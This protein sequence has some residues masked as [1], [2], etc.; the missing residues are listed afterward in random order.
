MSAAGQATGNPTVAGG[1]NSGSAVG[2]A[3]GVPTAANGANSGTANGEATGNP[4]NVQPTDNSANVRPT[5]NP[6]AEGGLNSNSAG[7]QATANSANDQVPT[8]SADRQ[9]SGVPTAV[10]DGNSGSSGPQATINP[11]APGASDL[12][13]VRS[14]AAA[15]PTNAELGPSGTKGGTGLAGPPQA[16]GDRADRFR[17][18]RPQAGSIT[19][20]SPVWDDPA[21][22]QQNPVPSYAPAHA[23]GAT[24]T[25]D[26]NDP[27]NDGPTYIGGTS[28][29]A[30]AQKA[31]VRA[32]QGT[33][34][35][36]AIAQLEK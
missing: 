29:N 1:E 17:D 30:A 15:N 11:S 7:G 5:N 9:P 21:L 33:Y 28:P 36:F 23:M 27:A 31:D 12:G 24:G 4:T 26:N 13:S 20:T 19:D 18:A 3:S 16:T 34:Q 35:D 14:Q 25:F 22:I 32:N 8:N 2:Q 6:S 10:N